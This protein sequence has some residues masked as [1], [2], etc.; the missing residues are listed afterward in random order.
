MSCA[1]VL[2]KRYANTLKF[3]VKVLA[4]ATFNSDHQAAVKNSYQ[5]ANSNLAVKNISHTLW[6][7]CI[8]NSIELLLAK[9]IYLML[10]TSLTSKN[11]ES[12]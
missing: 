10:L 4:A 12:V 11:S 8:V 2:L 6:A 3:S 1:P 9:A 5:D 7:I